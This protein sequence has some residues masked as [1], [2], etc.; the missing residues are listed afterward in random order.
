[1]RL[2]ADNAGWIKF[3]V[4]CEFERVT[5]ISAILEDAKARSVS[6]VIE[7]AGRAVVAALFDSDFDDLPRIQSEIERTESNDQKLQIEQSFLADRDWVAESQQELQP[8]EVGNRLR[9]VAPWHDVVGDARTTVIIN[10]G[11]S[12]GT[13]HHETT[14]MCANFLTRL[15]LND[16]T[17][18]DY[19]CGS[20][21]LAVSALL[22]GA[23]SAW[24]VDID[25]D[26]LADSRDN[27]TRNG[28]ESAYWTVSP[29]DLPHDFQADVVV[30]NLFADALE[31]LSARLMQLVRPGGW[32]ALSGILRSQVNNVQANYVTDFELTPQY[33]GQWAMLTGRRSS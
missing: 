7:T 13:G 20:G 27:A 17:V 31:E 24:G 14:Y 6:I 29:E 2:A 28:V 32:I 19:G 12:F 15:E 21:V 22:L 16:R 23:K 8:L 11:I 10:P 9:I 3:S 33:L 5:A 18:V 26:A 30:A 25:P 4:K 1:M